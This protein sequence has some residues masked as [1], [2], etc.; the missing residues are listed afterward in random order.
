VDSTNCPDGLSPED[1]EKLLTEVAER[2]G[3]RPTSA[4]LD[5]TALARRERREAQRVLGA[6]L[7]VL[8]VHGSLAVPSETEAA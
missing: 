8:R 5:G 2:T 1:I 7:R 4:L 6:T 3:P